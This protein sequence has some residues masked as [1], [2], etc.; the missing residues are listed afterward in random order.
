M[1]LSFFNFIEILRLKLLP[2]YFFN[3]VLHKITLLKTF[4][5]A[6]VQLIKQIVKFGKWILEVSYNS[7]NSAEVF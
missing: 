1:I 3:G 2:I 6:R 7:L 5:A 4:V